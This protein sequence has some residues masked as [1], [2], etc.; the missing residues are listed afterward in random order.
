MAKS[1]LV[2]R[3]KR[4]PFTFHFFTV[5]AVAFLAATT[6][7]IN[8]LETSERASGLRHMVRFYEKTASFS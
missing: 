3:R 1:V 4:A 5:A 2:N 8:W 6:K 7:V